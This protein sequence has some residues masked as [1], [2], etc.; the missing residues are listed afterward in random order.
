MEGRGMEKV[1]IFYCYFEYITAI[2]YMLWPFGNLATIWY[3]F[4]PFWY[5]VSR[6]CWQPWPE[7]QFYRKK[8]SLKSRVDVGAGTNR[9]PSNDSHNYACTLG[10]A[11]KS[12]SSLWNLYGRA[13]LILLQILFS[14][15]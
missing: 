8:S 7:G 12:F 5:I 15:Y 11:L 1:G 14:N 13:N 3:I 4:R 9:G 2:W 6:K 10:Q